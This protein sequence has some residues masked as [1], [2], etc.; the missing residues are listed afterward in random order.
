MAR[1]AHT[2]LLAALAVLLA[3]GSLAAASSGQDTSRK[4]LQGKQL[5]H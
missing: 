4:L 3:S 1:Y 5:L 2:I